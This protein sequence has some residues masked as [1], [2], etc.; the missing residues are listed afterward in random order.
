MNPLARADWRAE[1]AY[2]FTEAIKRKAR[3]IELGPPVCLVLVDRL[4]F[5]PSCRQFDRADLAEDSAAFTSNRVGSGK[6]GDEPGFD[7]KQGR[8]YAWPRSARDVRVPVAFSDSWGPALT[9]TQEI[10]ARFVR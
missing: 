7:V 9:P 6:G 4:P 5:Q 1:V 10:A 2:L 3:H 8:G